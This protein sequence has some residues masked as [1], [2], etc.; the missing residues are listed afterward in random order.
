MN[1]D[2]VGMGYNEPVA[3]QQNEPVVRQP[4]ATEERQITSPAVRPLSN[5]RDVEVDEETISNAV[6]VANR[7]LELAG[8]GTRL[9]RSLHEATRQFQIQVVNAETDEVIREV[10]RSSSL[11]RFARI[12]ELAGLLVD[13]RH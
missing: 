9:R 5:Y 13:Q 8:A 10:P 3:L 4:A 2:S 1:I 12:M 6:D 11:D 7:A